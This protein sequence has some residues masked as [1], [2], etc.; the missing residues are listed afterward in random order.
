VPGRYFRSMIESA[1][2]IYR[3]SNTFRSVS[4][5]C[6][7]ISTRSK[8]CLTPNHFIRVDGKIWTW[9]KFVEDKRIRTWN[10]KQQTANFRGRIETD[11]IDCAG[12][13]IL[14]GSE[15]DVISRYGMK[16]GLVRDAISFLTRL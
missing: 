5:K 15:G 12:I 10:S 1:G 2:H 9:A 7:H 13:H 16:D 8:V 6:A 3:F 4:V 14:Q 11:H